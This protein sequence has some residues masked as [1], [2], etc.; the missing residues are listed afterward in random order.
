MV[1]VARLGDA[2]DR[3]DQ[4]AAADLLG[5]A[6]GQLL[7]GPVERVAGLEGDDL[8]PTLVLEVLAK[9][10]GRPA[11]LGEVVVRRDADHFE[12]AGGVLAG[13]ALEVGDG[14]VL[15]IGRAVR[16]L[17]LDLLVEGIELLDVEEGQQVAVDVAEGQWLA[18]L[19]A[20]CRA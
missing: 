8:R 18:N 6:L 11:K 3:M 7:V 10:L 2:H 4:Q 5:R 9:L 17:G 15:D 20:V 16:P 12:A 14:G 1:D 13:L 19:D